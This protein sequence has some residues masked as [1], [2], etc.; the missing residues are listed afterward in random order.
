MRFAIL[1][2]IHAN[3]AAFEAVL[4]DIEERGGVH[5]IWCL[6]DI[7]GYGPDPS[8]CIAMLRQQPHVCVAGNHDWAAIGKLD[9]SEFNP[10]AAVACRWTGEQ[11][12]RAADRRVARAR[13]RG[14]RGRGRAPVA[15]SDDAA[16]QPGPRRRARAGLPRLPDQPRRALPQVTSHPGRSAVEC[17]RSSPGP[18]SVTECP[19]GYRVRGFSRRIP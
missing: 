16:A 19:P 7:V 11:L 13:A 12:G 2:D 5:Q 10:Y 15:R 1:A 18:R 6:G 3:L 9:V 14:A 4:Q 8:A 17:S